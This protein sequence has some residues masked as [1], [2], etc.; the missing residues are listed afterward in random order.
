MRA[1]RDRW[2]ASEDRRDAARDRRRAF[3][4]R[5]LLARRVV[6]AETDALTGARSR[7]AGL[8]E[9]AREVER[10]RRDGA[11]LAVVYVDVVGLKH[12]NDTEGHAAGDRLLVQVAD[13]VR[14]QMRAYD[15]VV[16]LGGDEFLVVMPGATA[17]QARVRIRDVGARLAAD[18]PPAALR[19]GVS[20]LLADHDAAALVRAADADMVRHRRLGDGRG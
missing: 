15:S 10:C 6:D 9:L 8:R 13:A 2:A 4:D 7:S 5:D 1:A 18:Q 20:A 17:E 11:A 16:R 19:A 3:E 12:V 14:A